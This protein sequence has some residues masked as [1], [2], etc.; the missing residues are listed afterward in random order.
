MFSTRC[1]R[2]PRIRN[3]SPGFIAALPTS[4]TTK[5]IPQISNSVFCI[6]LV[7][8]IT[9]AVVRSAVATRN[10]SFTQDEGYHI[11]AGVSYAKRGDF[12]INPE[13]PP[14]VKLWVGT[15]ISAAGF[16]LSPFREMHDKADERD[17]AEEDIYQHNDP[18]LVQRRA[19]KAMWALNALLLAGFAFALRRV[20]GPVA[21][22]C[23]LSVL[24]IDPTIAA[25]MPLVLTDLPISLLAATAV[26]L[27]SRAFRE[28]KVPDLVATSAVLGMALATKH[29]AP[30]FAIFLALVGLVMACF[31]PPSQSSD[32]RPLRFAKL[33][34][35]LFG[36]LAILWGFYLFRFTES[37]SPVEVFNRPLVEK[38]ADL[39]SPLH[40]MVLTKF[41]SAHL[42]PRPYIWG[43]ADTIR[44]GIEG[45]VETRL[46]Y[47]HMYYAN[48]PWYFFPGV[49]AAKLPL[50]SLLLIVLGIFLFASRRLPGEWRTSTLVVAIVVVG[51]LGVL[52]RGANYGG[53]RHA[54]PLAVL[55]YIF[56][57]LALYAALV[58]D[59]RVFRTVAVLS[60][61]AAAISALPVMRPYEYYNETIGTSNA[62]LYFNDESLD[63]E[64]RGK[65]LFAYY[66]KKVKP[67]GDI[68]FLFYSVPNMEI[69]A[70]GLDYVGSDL[71]RDAARMSDS[72]VT[73]TIFM[74]ARFLSQQPYWRLTA[75]ESAK[76]VARFGNLLIFQGSFH[77][78][79]VAAANAYWAGTLK[80]YTDKPDLVE[81]ERLFRQSVQLDSSA[82]YVF[83]ELGN[84]ALARGSREEAL[85]AYQSALQ[86][87]PTP[88]LAEPIAQQIQ[89]I[90][91]SPLAQIRPLRNPAIE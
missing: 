70:R 91:H 75:L 87:A 16:H 24:V 22:L 60:L 20:F 21:A 85:V 72:T 39:H 56:A 6:L 45:R 18:D 42:L 4:R 41:A 25:H 28:W 57:G 7:C 80:E 77:L 68:P 43:F 2:L 40:R 5:R 26:V 49:I 76:P 3:P 63:A 47:G 23:V 34:G 37:P 10:D 38:I 61:A 9:G 33:A 65:D 36:A 83:I 84:L 19:R 55:L 79:A 73:G 48:P 8:L 71:K 88:T 15:I 51:F 11:L 78:P 1:C 69:K 31:V 53:L 27:A 12:R 44:A 30:V 29:S 14:L 35:V 54:L 67:A 58:S 82:F 46:F 90:S 32:R 52:S 17:F 50:G 64:Q 59:S 13:H 81:A 74:E 89:Q 62:Y 86:G 66:F